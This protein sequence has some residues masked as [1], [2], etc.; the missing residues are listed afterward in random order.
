MSKNTG[1]LFN[2]PCRNPKRLQAEKTK[3]VTTELN[4]SK[5]STHAEGCWTAHDPYLRST[6]HNQTPPNA[7]KLRSMSNRCCQRQQIAEASQTKQVVQLPKTICHA[8]TPKKSFLPFIASSWSARAAYV[9][10]YTT[11]HYSRQSPCPLHLLCKSLVLYSKVRLGLPNLKI[12]YTSQD[13][14]RFHNLSCCKAI[15]SKASYRVSKTKL[16]TK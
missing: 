2:H 10:Q 8:S 1:A 16:S 13:C 5:R 3:S 14:L 4:R 12:I 9:N 7:I 15:T 11:H 6:Y